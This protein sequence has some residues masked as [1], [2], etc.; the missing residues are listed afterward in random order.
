MYWLKASSILQKVCYLF[1]VS[2][3]RCKK[4]VALAVD[5]GGSAPSNGIHFPMGVVIVH[6]MEVSMSTPAF[7]K[8]RSLNP[9]ANIINPTIGLNV[10]FEPRRTRL[11]FW[12]IR[13][14]SGS[15]VF[16]FVIKT[17]LLVKINSSDKSQQT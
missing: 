9:L 16:R 17:L 2:A 10:V 14:P 13:A 4:T 8:H 3:I 15:S 7:S 12:E 1:A 11:L 6:H 5:G